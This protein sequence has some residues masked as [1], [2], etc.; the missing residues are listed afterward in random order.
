MKTHKANV[1]FFNWWAIL[2]WWVM[3]ML[4]C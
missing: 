3:L 4:T 2:F 1:P